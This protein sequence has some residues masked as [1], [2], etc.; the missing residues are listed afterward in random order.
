MRLLILSLLAI[1]SF[2]LAFPVQRCVNLDQALEAPREGDWGFVIQRHQIAWIADQGFDTIRLP[3]RLS[4][5]W[6]NELSAEILARLDEVINWAFEDDLNVILDLHHFEALMETPSRHAATFQAIG[7]ELAQ[8]YAGYD[9]RLIFELLNEPTED[10]DTAEAMVLFRA[11]YPTIR[12]SNPDRWIIIEGGQ[13]ASVESLANL[14]RI[15]SRTALSFH[16]YKPWEFT[17]QQA[18]W[19]DNP[20]PARGWGHKADKSALRADFELA[21]NYGVPMLLG[22]FGVTS[23]TALTERVN[24]TRAVREE[25][26]SHGISW[27]HW[28]LA[29][30]FAIMSNDTQEWLPGMKSALLE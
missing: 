5:H 24:W 23:Q 27:C 17:H 19:M 20:P 28:G 8:H 30:N 10:L 22:E 11:V 4:A 3:V 9:E 25:A 16:Y 2:L 21:A 1:P 14:E 15:D 13:W 12:G 29:G 18:G 26:E 6:D 7:T